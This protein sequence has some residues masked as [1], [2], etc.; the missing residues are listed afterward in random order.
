MVLL[1]A[2]F[3]RERASDFS[4]LRRIPSTS[5]R[6][7]LDYFSALDEAGKDALAEGLAQRALLSIF[8]PDKPLCPTDNVAYRQYV[9]ALPLMWDWKY[10]DVRGLRMLLA[11]AKLEP[12]SNIGISVTDDIRGWIEGIKPVKSTEIRKVVKLALSQIITPLAVT[13]EGQ[14][15][16][17]EGD[18]QGRAV[19]VTIDYSHRYHQLDYTVSVQKQERG[20]LWKG[21]NYERLMGLSFADWDCLEQGNLDQ[22]IALL[23]EIIVHCAAVHQLLLRSYDPSA[24][25]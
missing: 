5:V 19:S 1:R 17:Y 12:E 22:S 3:K 16:L 23:K 8:P 18:F 15:W 11:V 13:H 4:V 21:L 9:D 6:K 10:E 14:Y 2:E 7:F 24:N 25:T 20:I